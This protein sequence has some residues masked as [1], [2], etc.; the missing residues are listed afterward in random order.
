MV[1]DVKKVK[2]GMYLVNKYVLI[3]NIQDVG[4]DITYD[5]KFNEKE[6]SEEEAIQVADT[7]IK[8]ALGGEDV[9]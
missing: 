8:Q 2:N 5:M 3:S 7:F 4:D 1:N 9:S 6:I